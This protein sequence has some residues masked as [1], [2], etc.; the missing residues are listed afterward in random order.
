MPSILAL[1][2]QKLATLLCIWSQP[3]LHSELQA[4][5]DYAERPCLKKTERKQKIGCVGD[6]VCTCG[7]QSTT[8][9]N[10]FFPPPRGSWE[11]NSGHQT[12]TESTLLLS[13]IIGPIIFLRYG[14]FNELGAWC[15][16]WV[17]WLASSREGAVCLPLP[18]SS[19][20]CR[21]TP[22]RPLF[23]KTITW[24]EHPLLV[25]HLGHPL[26]PPNRYSLWAQHLLPWCRLGQSCPPCTGTL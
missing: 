10:Q 26:A 17:S 14:L 3:G 25:S 6:G 16:V 2:K 8:C 19:R 7:G 1:R 11:L 13:H 4:S 9:T 12:C 5:H 20:G 15:L 18:L 22:S 24:T 21:D 23:K